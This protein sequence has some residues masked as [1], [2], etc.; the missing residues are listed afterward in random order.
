MA[1]GVKIS[2]NISL[3]GG[4]EEKKHDCLET[5]EILGQSLNLF[6]VL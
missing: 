3:L 2:L 4:L 6:L 5:E 1:K